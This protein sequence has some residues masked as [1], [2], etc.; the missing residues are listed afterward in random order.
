MNEE[1]TISSTG[2]SSPSGLTADLASLFDS[3]QS[4]STDPASLIDRQSVVAS[5]QQLA[6]EFNQV[7]PRSL[8]R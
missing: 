4:L 7:F 6:T 5:A 2:T 1:I 8:E 3:F